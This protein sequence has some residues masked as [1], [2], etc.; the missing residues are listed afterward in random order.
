MSKF[1]LLYLIVGLLIM[2]GSVVVIAQA[3]GMEQAALAPMGSTP[4]PTPTDPPTPTPTN[5]PKPER[6]PR[7]Q[8]GSPS[9]PAVSVLLSSAGSLGEMV[10]QLLQEVRSAFNR[11]PQ[12]GSNASAATIEGIDFAPGSSTITMTIIPADKSINKGEPISIKFKP[13]KECVFGDKQACVSTYQPS[14]NGNV[15]FVSVHSGFGSEAQALRHAL[16]G[17][18]VTRA[19]FSLKEIE[20]NLNHMVG[21][22]VTL[23]Q[24]TRT[25]ADLQIKTMARVP[26]RSIKEYF[27]TP[28]EE[29][30]S[31]A[32]EMNPQLEDYLLPSET[33][34]V[35][36]TCG[37]RVVGEPWA[38][39]VS[40][41]TAGVYLGVIQQA[42]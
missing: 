5:P 4:T 13:G 17:T 14:P 21:A 20:A 11:V 29:A 9:N 25:V 12:A 30:L 31:F 42:P 3:S 22:T 33:Q 23:Q 6:T 19:D 39:G 2:L 35:I 16:E 40:M 1:K 27:L 18:K 15:I 36:E 32:T 41:T 38:D 10:D 7:P 24:G 28:V 37:W 8:P 34:I 26:T